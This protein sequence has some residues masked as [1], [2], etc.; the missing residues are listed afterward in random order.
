MSEARL[1]AGTE[2]LAVDEM[3]RILAL[4]AMLPPV[5]D[6]AQ[7][8]SPGLCQASL[9]QIAGLTPQT[10]GFTLWNLKGDALCSAQPASA[11][12][13]VAGTL[14][15]RMVLDTRAL[16]VGE[17]ELAA[18]ASQPTLTFG[19]PVTSSAGAF[20]GVVSSGLDLTHLTQ[21]ASA[22]ALPTDALLT[23]FDHNGIVLARTQAPAAWLGKPE[24][25]GLAAS[26][27]QSSGVSEQLGSDGVRRV[28][29]YTPVTGP[30]GSL[31]YLGIARPSVAVFGPSDTALATSLAI[32]GGL[33]VLAVLLAGWWA[34]QTLLRPM[35]GLLAAAERQARG[36]RKAR[37]QPEPAGSELDR[38][39]TAFNGLAASLE[40]LETDLKQAQDNLGEAEGQARAAAEQAARQAQQSVARA[41]QLETVTAGLSQAV[42]PANVAD[43][44]L[45]QGAGAV[46]ATAATLLVL[47]EDGAWL[48][49]AAGVGYSDQI[50]RL[51]QQ[52]PVSSPLP[53]ADVLR[54]GE[55]VWLESAAA[56]RARYPQLTEVINSAD[57]EAAAALPLR[58]AGRIIGVLALSF[59][60]AQAFS[61]DVQSYLVTLASFCAQA[62]ERIRLF[63]ET[64]RLR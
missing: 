19:Y 23:V 4:A 15:F 47:S 11:S 5:R 45:R 17:F 20:V 40:Q 21:P 44:I 22:V 35:N 50:G 36:D 56:Y 41:A 63:E 51:F 8:G 7:T 10:L 52:Y 30:G 43:V 6:A 42:T 33:A 18:A 26:L 9:A 3:G 31:V 29:A 1:A 16:A 64:Q 25:A 24:A 12:A 54:M 61:S 55:A 57:Y 28:Y 2:Q 27:N 49:R 62:L 59:P 14:W 46:G 60:N 58:Y 38:L 32:S 48:R 37:A 53:P 34:R 13:N 39:A